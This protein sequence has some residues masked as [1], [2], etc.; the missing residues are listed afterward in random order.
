MCRMRCKRDCLAAAAIGPIVTLSL[1]HPI[2]SPMFL[3]VASILDIK[4]ATQNSRVGAIRMGSN[5]GFYLKRRSQSQTA[6]KSI[7]RLKL[8]NDA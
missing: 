3:I 7:R 4:R 6:A 2:I 1:S 5:L 8:N